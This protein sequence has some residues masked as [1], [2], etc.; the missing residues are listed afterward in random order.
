MNDNKLKHLEFIQNA[1]GRMAHNSFLI[2]GWSI[3]I[4]S[5]L[6]VLLLEKTSSIEWFGIAVIILTL[7]AFSFLD[8]Y[9]LA[10]ERNFREV[11]DNVRKKPDIEI[12]F[13]MG[14]SHITL[15]LLWK[16]W[17]SP[18]ILVYLA[19]FALILFLA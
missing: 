19:P 11:Y 12:D 8:A 17:Y 5:A 1:I 7:V 2:K 18:S 9:Y 14:K 16:S 3:S 13:D 4:I 15:S 10:L 6:T